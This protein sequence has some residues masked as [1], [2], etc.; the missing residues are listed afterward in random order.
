MGRNS[1]RS[2]R[3]SERC[4][5]R[6]A[7]GRSAC[8][9]GRRRTRVR[10]AYR[11]STSPA[12]LTFPAGG[13]GGLA[14]NAIPT[15]ARASIDFRLVPDQ[16]P[17]A[18]AREGGGAPSEARL[19]HRARPGHAG[20]AAP[21]APPGRAWPGGRAIRRRAPRWTCRSRAPSRARSRRRAGRRSSGC[22]RWGAAW[23]WSCSRASWTSGR[24]AAHREPRQQPA[25]G[26]REPAPPEPV[27]RDRGLRGGDDARWARSGTRSDRG[28]RLSRG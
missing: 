8:R 27:G 2:V 25:R 20:G 3:W 9:N 13:V 14:A 23:A 22:P 7:S 28:R 26:G 12:G 17:A 4:G 24:G 5:Y 1:L 16:T 11:R 21:A 18:R 15:E 6:P 10:P 19:R